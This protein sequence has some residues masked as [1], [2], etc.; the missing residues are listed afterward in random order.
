MDVSNVSNEVNVPKDN[1]SVS[2]FATNY[3]ECSNNSSSELSLPVQGN[4]DSAILYSPALVQITFGTQRVACVGLAIWDYVH[5]RDLTRFSLLLVAGQIDLFT[6]R[7]LLFKSIFDT[8]LK[9]IAK[10]ISKSDTSD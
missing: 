1:I 8:F 7:N 4:K 9:A 2:S 3:L 10:D 6:L 5:T